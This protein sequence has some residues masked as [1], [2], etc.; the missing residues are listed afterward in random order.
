[1]KIDPKVD[2]FGEPSGKFNCYVLYPTRTSKPA[3]LEPCKPDVPSPPSHAQKDVV[4]SIKSWDKSCEHS[5]TD[6]FRCLGF[7]LEWFALVR[8]TVSSFLNGREMKNS[9]FFHKGFEHLRRN[10]E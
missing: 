4:D 1:M 10:L 7:I 3:T 9:G 8:L 2:L 5:S 6:S